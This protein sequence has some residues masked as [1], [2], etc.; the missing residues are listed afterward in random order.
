MIIHV[1]LIQIS[2]RSKWPY[3]TSEGNEEQNQRYKSRINRF[4]EAVNNRLLTVIYMEGKVV[5]LNSLIIVLTAIKRTWFDTTV[6]EKVSTRDVIRRC[7]KRQ[8]RY[9]EGISL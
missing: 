7:M 5:T 1:I 2:K 3:S 4:T 8:Q 9:S 6:V